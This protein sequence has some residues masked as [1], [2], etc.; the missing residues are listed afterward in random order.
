MHEISPSLLPELDQ[1]MAGTR[2]TFQRI[3]SDQL[4]WRP[5]EKSWTMLQLAAHLSHVPWWGQAT[6]ERTSFDI[7][8]DGKPVRGPQHDDVDGLLAA[9]DEN[10]RS[11]RRAIEET[12]DDH[13]KENWTLLNHGATVFTL[14][15]IAVYRNMVMNHMIH[16]RGQLTVYLRMTGARVPGLYGPSGD[17]VRG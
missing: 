3:P 1:E 11:L 16:H 9:F 15:R 5:H 13:W 14:P 7:A 4:D 2:K 17:D 8:P 6:L 10:V 12:S